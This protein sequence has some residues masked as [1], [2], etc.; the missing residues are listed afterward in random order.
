MSFDLHDPHHSD[1]TRAVWLLAVDLAGLG[2]LHLRGPPSA[3]RDAGLAS[4][5]CALPADA[6]W[7]R[8]PAQIDDDRL[9]G[10]LDLALSLADQARQGTFMAVALRLTW[11]ERVRSIG[12]AI[13]MVLAS[14]ARGDAHVHGQ[15][16]GSDVR[17]PMPPTAP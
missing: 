1:A 10:G 11:P 7:R 13:V 17:W 15:L 8:L 3:A 5:Q 14:P 6:P 16:V 12:R 4:L 2:G 9:L